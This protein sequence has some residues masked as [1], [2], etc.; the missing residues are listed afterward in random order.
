[1]SCL[2]IGYVH[3]SMHTYAL[4]DSICFYLNIDF[5]FSFPVISPSGVGRKIC[6]Y[7]ARLFMPILVP[8]WIEDFS[9]QNWMQELNFHS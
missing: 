5:P 6:Q 7:S 3:I 1:M 8:K 9:L 4:Y 2:A